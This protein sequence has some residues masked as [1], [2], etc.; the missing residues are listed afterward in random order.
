MV[1]AL[2]LGDRLVGVTHECNFPVEARSK[3]IVVRSAL[4]LERATPG[5]IDRL[6]AERLRSGG[7]LYVVDEDLLRR[8]EPDLIVTQ[9]LCQVCAPSG[10]EITRALAALPR[11]PEILCMTPRSVDGIFECL[12]DLGRSTATEAR[13]E[14]IVAGCRARITR[15]QRTLRGIGARPRVFAMEWVEPPYC[16]GHW[17]P[18]MVGIAGG[19]DGLGRGGLDSARIAWDEV[20]AWA[21]EV[22]I[23]A[24]CG[25]PLKV[26]AG[27]ATALAALPGWES[28]PAVRDGRVF[29]VDADSYFARPGPRVV[30][31]I[32]LIAH[33]LRPQLFPWKGAPNAF[34][35]VS[36]PPGPK[37]TSRLGPS[38]HDRPSATTGT[39]LVPPRPP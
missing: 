18:E 4:D 31:G 7:S 38:L 15:V 32:E 26:A 37:G 23:V 13:A 5:E 35:W 39:H 16:A 24:P 29:A 14:K 30:D 11:P 28:I 2:G 19:F 22:L 6:V 17:V 3:P 20:L 10:H 8:L 12:R 27:Q 33:L 21:P 9:D 36:I 1:F 25:F 34:Q